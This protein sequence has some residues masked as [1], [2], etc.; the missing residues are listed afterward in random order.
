[1]GKYDKYKEHWRRRAE[2]ERERRQALA[3]EA[4]AEAQRLGHLLT[5]E[6][7][8]KKVYLFGSLVREDRFY[9]RSD[10][11]LAAEGIEPS[12]FFKAAAALDRACDYRYQIDLVDLKT[13]RDGVKQLILTEG[14]LLCDRTGD[15]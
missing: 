4:R 14:V 15:S 2:K 1:M 8:A 6:F 3:A 10:I 7:G 9:E 11:D 5:Q 13:A 12:Q